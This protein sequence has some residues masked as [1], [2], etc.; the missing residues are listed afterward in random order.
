MQMLKK[1]SYL[2]NGITGRLKTAVCPACGS[3]MGQAVDRKWFHSLVE[4]NR[5]GLLH[6][7]PC[8]SPRQMAAF[9]QS[10]YSQT[11]L[12]TDLPSDA[13][14]KTLI[15]TAFRGSGKDFRYHARVLEALRPAGRRL[16]DYGANWGYAAWQFAR[17]GFEVT[18]YEI[19]RPRAE[20]GAK[21]GVKIHTD[22]ANV[23]GPFDI[24]HSCHVLEH[25][26]DPL[27]ALNTQLSMLK[28]GG[29]LAAHTPNGTQ[30]YRSAAQ[31]TFRQTWGQVHPVLL[32]DKFVGYVARSRPY[33]V[34]SND[35]PENVEAWDQHSQV[36][37]STA[38]VGFFFA[39]KNALSVATN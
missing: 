4:C 36:V 22:L 20:F 29:M 24:I 18:S 39:I 37:E 7:Y 34:T 31:G 11:G 2:V 38:D 25:V 12:T 10:G 26:A 27:A 9:Y 23:D 1:A 3:T 30:S 28:P 32:N 21:L 13:E 8:E 15:V 5:C 33:L 35:S 17:L 19:S 14:L 16:L 6:R